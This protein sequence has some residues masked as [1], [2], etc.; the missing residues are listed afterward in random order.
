METERTMI[1]NTDRT[2]ILA[3]HSK[4]GNK[5]LCHVCGLD[6]IDM[7]ITD[8][9]PENQSIL[10]KLTEQNLRIFA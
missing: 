1:E 3:D 2:I 10:K 5:A 7:L 8:K 6:C 4:L 9:W